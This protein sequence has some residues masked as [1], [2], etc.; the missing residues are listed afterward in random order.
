M[1]KA[2]DFC[3][4]I[5]SNKFFQKLP[6]INVIL[7]VCCI[8][9]NIN[10]YLFVSTIFGF[11]WVPIA[12]MGLIR[13]EKW[14]DRPLFNLSEEEI[15]LN[16]LT[17]E[18]NWK[19][20]CSDYIL[21]EDFMR[22]YKNNIHWDNVAERQNLKEKFIKE[23]WEHLKNYSITLAIFQKRNISQ[24]FYIELIDNADADVFYMD[25]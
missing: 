10:I 12:V 22:K 11:I 4:K 16:E 15:I 8:F 25:N 2:L 5:N 21:T 13:S 1:F 20:I 24:K 9:L 3:H 14:G 23:M 7:A 6:F 18:N 19:E 17:G